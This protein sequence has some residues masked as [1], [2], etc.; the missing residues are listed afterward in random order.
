MCEIVNRKPCAART[1][2]IYTNPLS[3]SATRD[4]PCLPLLPEWSN[5]QTGTHTQTLNPSPCSLLSTIP[6]SGS[7]FHSPPSK[8]I[9]FHYLQ[10]FVFSTYHLHLRYHLNPSFHNLT[11]V[12]ICP[13][14]DPPITDQLLPLPLSYQLPPLHSSIQEDATWSADIPQLVFSSQLYIGPISGVQ[15]LSG[16]GLKVAMVCLNV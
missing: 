4:C 7:I 16:A 9:W 10:P 8:L 11:H 1:T 12:P 14:L 3:H 6:P 15:D 2:Y 5:T 13:F